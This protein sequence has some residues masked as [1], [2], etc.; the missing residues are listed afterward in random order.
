MLWLPLDKIENLMEKETKAPHAGTNTLLSTKWRSFLQDNYN[1]AD[2][3]M[4]IAIP[5]V[6]SGNSLVNPFP[7]NNTF[8]RPWE[9]SLLKT[10]W[11]KNKLL[12]TSNFSFSHKVFYLFG[13][14]SFI[15]MKFKIVVYKLFQ[16]GRV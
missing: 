13:Q 8:W 2:H 11:E 1:D 15:F 10:L 5:R 14:L 12:V 7:H 4:A 16:F 3:T 9:T 6:F